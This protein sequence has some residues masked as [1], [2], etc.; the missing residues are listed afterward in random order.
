MLKVI[1]KHPG[2]VLTKDLHQK[3]DEEGF[4]T[5]IRTVE[6]D[7]SKLADVMGLTSSESPEGYKWAYINHSRELLPALSPNEA[8]LLLQAKQHLQNV[9]PFKALRSL[10]PR[11]DKAEAT[12]SQNKTMANWQD[13]IRVVQGMVPLIT[14]EINEDIRTHVYEAILKAQ[15][16][17]IRYQKNSGDVG[18]Y[19]LNTHGLIIKDYVQYLV[20]S[21]NTSPDLL[22]LFKL[23]QIQKVTP[24]YCDNL[25]CNEDVS[26]FI[27][28][29]VS[30]FIIEQKPIVLK[31]NITGPALTLLSN[32][33]LCDDQ[34]L[35]Y[36]TGSTG[37]KCALLTATV[38]FTYSLLHFLL[39]Y[40]K[41]VKVLAPQSLINAIEDR[42]TGDVF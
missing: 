11:F 12:L 40:G 29:D 18:S 16:V 41:S 24:Q 39:G 7:L 35:A 33:K 22:Q 21:K 19:I 27:H 32:A 30:G 34:T 14:A 1:P 4:K 3:L 25:P 38:D 6:R 8:L 37:N 26:A 15:Q 36:F 17:N 31:M 20:A 42:K 9:M 28:S 5:S 13:K 23:S 10:E 2:F